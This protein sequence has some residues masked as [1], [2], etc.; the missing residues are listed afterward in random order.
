MTVPGSFGGGDGLAREVG[1]EGVRGISWGWLLE[2]ITT[3][4]FVVVGEGWMDTRYVRR[5]DIR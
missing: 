1:V 2:K 3:L 4:G 5:S